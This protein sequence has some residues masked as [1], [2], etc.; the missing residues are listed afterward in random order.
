MKRLQKLYQIRPVELKYYT[1]NGERIRYVPEDYIVDEI[2]TITEAF[3]TLRSYRN[4]LLS[5]CDWTQI[6]DVPLTPE[7]KIEWQTYRQKLRDFPE[8]ID[9][10]TWSAV[11]WPL[12]PGEIENIVEET[13]YDY[14]PVENVV[15]NIVSVEEIIPDVDVIP[16]SNTLIAEP[17]EI[18]SETILES[19]DTEIIDSNENIMQFGLN[20]EPINPHYVKHQLIPDIISYED[21]EGIGSVPI[22]GYTQKETPSETPSETQ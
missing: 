2:S 7:Q 11:S 20:N 1:Y 17:V 14:P 9:T 5:L 13:I 4:N 15:K 12:A 22:L 6:V 8:T 21:S 10:N 19:S 16:D 3:D 18:I